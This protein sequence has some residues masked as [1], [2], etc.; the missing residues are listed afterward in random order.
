MHMRKR[1]H[2]SLMLKPRMFVADQYGAQLEGIRSTTCRA[3]LLRH[4]P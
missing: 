4:C 1:L 2:A 3:K